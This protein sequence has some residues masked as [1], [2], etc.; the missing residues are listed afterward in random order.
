[1]TLGSDSSCSGRAPRPATRPARD[2]QAG[3]NRTG[4]RCHCD[5]RCLRPGIEAGSV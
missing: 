4:A 2:Q 1:M 5:D 3:S